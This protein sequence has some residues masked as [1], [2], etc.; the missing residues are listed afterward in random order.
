M[1]DKT[2]S[3]LEILALAVC[4]SVGT[5]IAGDVTLDW[6]ATRPGGSN[7]ARVG[8]DG[9]IYSVTGTH[10]LK[11]DLDGNELWAAELDS[12]GG[13]RYVGE[14]LAIDPDGNIFVLGMNWVVL[15]NALLTMKFDPQGNLLWETAMPDS[16]TP[17]RI[18]TDDAGNAYVVGQTVSSLPD[19]VTAKYDPAG[20][21]LWREEFVGGVIN[22]AYGMAVTPSGDVAVVGRSNTANAYDIAVVVY[23][24][25][26]TQR[27]WRSHTSTSIGGGMDRGSSVA[28]GPAG[29]VYVGGDSENADDDWDTTLIKYDADGNEQWV[30]DYNVTPGVNHHDSILWIGVDSAGNILAAG[31]SDG[32]V[33]ALKYDADGTLLWLRQ[34][35][36][37]YGGYNYVTHMLVGPHDDAMYIVGLNGVHMSL[38]IK[39]DPDG[40]LGWTYTHTYGG[41]T[42]FWVWSVDL[43]P[44]N[45][46][47][48]G[49]NGTPVFHLLQSDCTLGAPAEVGG[50]MVEHD[51]VAWLP[52]SNGEQYDVARGDLDMLTSTGQLE[53][54]VTETAQTSCAE[55]SIPLPGQ[56]LVYLVRAVNL[57]GTGDWGSGSHGETRATTC[58]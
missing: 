5:A 21:L 58:P 39:Y 33:I 31:Q 54:H 32:N 25:D 17:R 2:R 8:Q 53:C 48:L 11:L 43:D 4:M 9:S 10:L 57:C 6:A 20:N 1:H 7:Q 35:D 29:E 56:V 55:N 37:G 26:G 3:G 45:N 14:R 22:E 18:E 42:N 47:V 23:D 38:A 15:P 40:T 44:G 36:G 49:K 13:E 19:F 27:W 24:T 52:G 50:V 41:W 12:S 51:R 30:R 34:H 28:F 46:V 16:E